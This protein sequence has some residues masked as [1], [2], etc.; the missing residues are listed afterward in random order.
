MVTICLHALFHMHGSTALLVT[1]IKRKTKYILHAAAMLLFCILQKKYHNKRCIFFD[2]F[3]H[4]IS[5]L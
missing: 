3:Y 4:T 1:A 2:Y 5:L